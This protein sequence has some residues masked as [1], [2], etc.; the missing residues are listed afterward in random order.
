MDPTESQWRPTS[1]SCLVADTL[2]AFFTK[3]NI[4]LVEAEK[5]MQEW[6]ARPVRVSN[7]EAHLIV[8][9]FTL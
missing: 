5:K 7:P 3:C 2:I 1:F 8:W 6:G 4:T 9:F